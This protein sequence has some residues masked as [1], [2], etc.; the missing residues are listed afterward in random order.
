MNL[1]IKEYL[2]NPCGTLSIPYWKTKNFTIPE[3]IAILHQSEFRGQYQKYQ[4]FFRLINNL[5]NTISK[6]N[7]IKSIHITE[8]LLQLINIC[9]EKENITLS[10]EDLYK[11]QK[12]PVYNKNLWVGIEENKKLI[13]CG[14][15]E[16]DQEIGEGSLEWVCVHPEY[17]RN[18]LGKK[19]VNE[20]C[21][22][23]KEL[24]A[25]FV[26][27]SGRIGNTSNPECFY[28][29]CGFTGSDIWYICNK[30]Q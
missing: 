22:R 14:I 11:M 16:F 27:V 3:T 2:D 26:T 6:F 9:F 15:A 23:L 1:T 19:I 21:Y 8:D 5:N 24:G 25:C 29:S 20:L 28:R 10:I 7:S 4:K 30:Q 17:Q 13:A 12:N 18:G